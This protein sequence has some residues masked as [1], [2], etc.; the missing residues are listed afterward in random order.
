[1]LSSKNILVT[2]KIAQNFLEN[3]LPSE[4]TKILD[5][6]YLTKEDKSYVDEDLKESHSDM[7]YKRE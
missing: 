5:L 6:H 7:L 4:I 1:M 3:Y 2:K